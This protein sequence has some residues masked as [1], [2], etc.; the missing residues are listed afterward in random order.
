M[1]EGKKEKTTQTSVVKNTSPSGT[2]SEQNESESV[3]KNKRKNTVNFHETMYTTA[4]GNIGY[5]NRYYRQ[6]ELLFSKTTNNKT[7]VFIL[8]FQ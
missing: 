3:V 8:F 2:V 4:I 7:P 1:I 6:R 5:L